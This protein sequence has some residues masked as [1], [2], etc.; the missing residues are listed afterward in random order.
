MIP[1]LIAAGLQL[2]EFVDRSLTAVAVAGVLGVVMTA[3]GLGRIA[4]SRL[5]Q[6]ADTAD[7]LVRGVE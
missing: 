1:D 7:V 2:A 5:T 6:A 3:V 4:W